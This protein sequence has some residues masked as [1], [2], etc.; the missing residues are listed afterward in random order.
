MGLRE[1]AVN[2]F[3]RMLGVTSPV[4]KAAAQA[5]STQSANELPSEWQLATYAPGWP[6]QP[7]TR[8]EDGLIPAR[9]TIPSLSTQRCNLAQ[10]TV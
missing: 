9:S 10:P 8:P 3:A 7:V 1:D 4:E 5:A 6:I 2:A